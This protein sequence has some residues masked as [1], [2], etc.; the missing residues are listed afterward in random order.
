MITKLILIR[1]GETDYTAKKIC[2]GFVNVNLNERGKWQAEKLALRLKEEKIDM[3]YSSDLK[4]AWMTAK[5][6]FANFPININLSPKLREMNFGIYEGLSYDYFISKWEEIFV[7]Q[8]RSFVK[9]SI[10][11]GESLVHLNKRVIFELNS[12]LKKH[13]ENK[14]GET[15]AIVSHSGPIKIILL[16]ALKAGLKNFWSIKQDL[17]ALN[18]VEYYDN[19]EG[20]VVSLV[21]DTCHLVD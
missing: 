14:Q 8:G 16:N 18:I 20:K 10:P 2:C 17:V 15:V 4:R 9:T 19:N 13:K 3:V 5:I 11:E 1:H 12:I 21:N 6:I 7:Q